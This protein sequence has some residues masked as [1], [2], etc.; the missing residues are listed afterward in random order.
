MADE[1]L[2]YRKVRAR[3]GDCLC[4]I[5]ARFGVV[6]CNRVRQEKKNEKLLNSP[7]RSGDDVGVP[8]LERRTGGGK[9]VEERHVFRRRGIPAPMIRF[10]HGSKS[11]PYRLDHSLTF[12]NI[13]N[14]V[15][16][17]GGLSHTPPP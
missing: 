12:L 8:T 10:V 7:L 13:S 14:Y 6:H 11:T 2:K 9:Q 15:S 4:G 17:L 1:V 3:D 5:A 16:N